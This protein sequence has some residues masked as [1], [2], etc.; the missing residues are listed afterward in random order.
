MKKV[1]VTGGMGFVGKQ[2]IELLIKKQYEVVVVDINPETQ[3]MPSTK[4][5]QYYSEDI[6]NERLKEIFAK[7][8]PSHVIHLAA[9]VDVQQS[10]NNPVHDAKT[11]IMGTVNLLKCCA[12]FGVKK[13]VYASSAAVY[14]VPQYLAVDEEHPC[15]PLSFYGISKLT[16][17]RYIKQF[18]ELHGLNFTILRYANVYGPKQQGNG[19]GG[20]IHTFHQNIVR[21]QPI[22]IFGT[23][24]QTRDFIYVKDVAAA[25]VAALDTN[26]NGTYNIGTNKPTSVNE[27]VQLMS[28]L[29][30]VKI[31]PIYEEERK[32]DIKHSYLHNKR[33][34][35]NLVWQPTYSLSEGL[36]ELIHSEQVNNHLQLT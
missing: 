13:I 1:L 31:E 30:H 10:I 3:C 17:E 16:P 33:A 32:G 15:N 25:N 34:I 26:Y 35:E 8:R 2:T 14:G 11:N 24:E 4:N 18:A 22:T 27:L 21:K 12:D 36:T 23:G 29:L 7:E 6:G 20:I 28:D 5:I 19:E 9:Q